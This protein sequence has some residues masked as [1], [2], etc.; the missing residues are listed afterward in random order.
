MNA[1]DRL[2][3]ALDQLEAHSDGFEQIVRA[4]EDSDSAFDLAFYKAL[5]KSTGTNAEARKGEAIEYVNATGLETQM[6]H[7]RA[8][9]EAAK[10]RGR[11]IRTVIEALRTMAAS[12]RLGI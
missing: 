1:N 4:F 6:R 9:L 12:E 10:E 5:A 7:A 3:L 11:N 8:V 2:D